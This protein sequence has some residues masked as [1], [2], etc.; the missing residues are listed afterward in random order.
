MGRQ[1]FAAHIPQHNI[2]PSAGKPPGTKQGHWGQDISSETQ[3]PHAPTLSSNTDLSRP[4]TVQSLKKFGEGS[5]SMSNSS[6][7]A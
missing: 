2:M 1:T 7:P 5:A 6:L 4:A 3:Q